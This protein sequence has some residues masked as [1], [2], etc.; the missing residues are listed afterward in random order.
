MKKS[1]ITE[2]RRI[3][4]EGKLLSNGHNVEVLWDTAYID[5]TRN[6]RVNVKCKTCGD[7]KDYIISSLSSGIYLCETCLFN[8]YKKACEDLNLRVLD[9]KRIKGNTKIRAECMVCGTECTH[10]AGQFL[11]KKFRCGGCL[12]IKYA[13]ACKKLNLKFI[14]K[15]HNG[16]CNKIHTECLVCGENRQIMSSDLL[17]GE[18]KCRT[19]TVNKYIKLLSN[20]KCTLVNIEKVPGK[21]SVI[22]YKNSVGDSFKSPAANIVAG[23]FETSLFGSWSQSHSVYL[24]KLKTDK[25]EYVYKIGTAND[26]YKRASE[27]KLNRPYEVFVLSEFETRYK[28]DKLESELHKEFKKY[29]LNRASVSSYTD[30]LIRRRYSDGSINMVKQGITEWFS[31]EV[32]PVLVHRYNLEHKQ[33]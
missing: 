4:I 21:K 33:F 12:L 22:H 13:D 27:L 28:A 1:N 15:A 30:S 24:I 11:D 18:F 20:K 9:S 17:K 6:V 23:S 25:D 19:C 3:K 8:K 26:A 7:I 32:F 16:L 5:N 14:A 31:S 10:S 29:R 2:A